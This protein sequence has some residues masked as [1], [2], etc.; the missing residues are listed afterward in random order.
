MTEWPQQSQCRIFYGNPSEAV[1]GIVRAN[2][3]WEGAN[4]TTVIV[5]WAAHASWDRGLKIGRLRVHK[6]CAQSLDWILATL[7][8]RASRSQA[9]IDRVG[10]SSIGGAHN[11]RLM[12]GGN[13][14]SMHAYGCAVDFDPE[15]NGMGDRTPNF[16]R[17]ENAYVVEV[18]AAEG[19]VW[20]GTFSN[21]DG[22]HFQAARV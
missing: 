5:P 10:L 15:R 7:W 11:W 3:V 6:K 9:E 4:L 8:S 16:A 2:K 20:G 19:W 1:R 17:P 18:F 14:L 22:M 13:A 21:P 12:R